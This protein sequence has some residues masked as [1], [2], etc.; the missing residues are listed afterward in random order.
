MTAATRIFFDMEFLEAARS[1]GESTDSAE[2][3]RPLRDGWSGLEKGLD[4]I[5]W[6]VYTRPVPGLAEPEVSRL[7]VVSITEG[8]TVT[9]AESATVWLGPSE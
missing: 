9:I 8:Q 4:A 7:V 6:Q 2:L 3:S 5:N 1:R